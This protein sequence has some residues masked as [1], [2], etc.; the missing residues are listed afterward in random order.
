VTD[1][2][3]RIGKIAF[4]EYLPIIGSARTEYYRNRLDFA[5]SDRR[6][7]TPEEMGDPEMIHE[8]GLGFHVPGKFDKVLDVKRC[9]LQM[10]PSN[11]IRLAIRTYAIENNLDFFDL[12]KQSGFLRSLVIRTTMAGDL[13]VL[14]SFFRNDKEEI[15]ALM[16]F[17]KNKFP[18]IS[19]LYYVINPKANDTM[20]D[21]EHYLYHGHLHIKEKLN[22][23]WY[24]SGPKSFFQ[25]N[26]FQAEVLFQKTKEM[27][28]LKGDE[29]AYDLYTGVGSIALYIANAVKKVIGIET[30]EEAI[31]FAKLNAQ[32]NK[33]DNA[34]FFAGDV[35]Y[36]F[37]DLFIEQH[38]KPDIIFTDPPRVGMDK[39]VVAQILRLAPEKVV[40]VSCNPATQARDLDWM[41]EMYR[42][43]AMQAVDMFPHTYHVENIAVL[44]KIRP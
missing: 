12:R 37:N 11:N 38:G 5:F 39:E 36:L 35:K 14:I 16:D 7:R 22:N 1:A 19:S 30:V 29:I 8:P 4:E 24:Q 40:Y 13:M 25:T 20:Y 15:N 2:M 44:E 28:G 43:I 23:I 42:P 6:W 41:R 31:A 3:Q 33:I 17:V 32:E 27:A 26:P 21:L 9:Y 34:D 18:Q 10:D